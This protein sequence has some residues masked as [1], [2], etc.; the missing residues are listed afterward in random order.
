LQ[1]MSNVNLRTVDHPWKGR[2]T[3]HVVHFKNLHL[4]YFS[5]MVEDSIVKFCARVGPH[6]N[7]S[8]SGRGHV[9][10]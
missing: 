1:A 9:T 6:D 2:S 7:L 10:S 3:D 8:P 5:G 4:L